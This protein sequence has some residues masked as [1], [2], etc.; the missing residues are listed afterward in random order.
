[1]NRRFAVA[2]W[3]GTFV[4]AEVDPSEF[5][6]P[7]A[8]DV[9]ERVAKHFSGVNIAMITP[10]WE[11]PTGIRVRGLHAPADILASPDLIWRDLHLP[12]EPDLPF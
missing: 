9:L 6:G 1:M 3:L 12:E 11:T 4:A 2:D 5:D 7:R 8:V 10:D